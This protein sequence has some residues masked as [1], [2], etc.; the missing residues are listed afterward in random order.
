[1]MM[2]RENEFP[3]STLMEVLTACSKLEKC[4][5]LYCH[6]IISSVNVLYGP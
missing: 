6:Y 4:V 2:I 3:N 5:N 1:M